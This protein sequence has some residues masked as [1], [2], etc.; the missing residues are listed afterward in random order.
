MQITVNANDINHGMSLVTRALSARPTRNVYE[1]VFAQTVE[2][3]VQLTCTDGIM[4]IRTIV[5]AVVAREGSALLPAKLLSELLRKLE[6]DIVIR[7]EES[8]AT[9]SAQGSRTN[10]LC[11]DMSEFPDIQDVAGDNVTTLPQNKLRDAVNRIIFAASSDEN[12]RIL[13][14]CLMETYPEEVRFVCLDGFRLA[15][16]RVYVTH[17]LPK[18]KDSMTSVIPSTVFGEIARMMPDSDNPATIVCSGTHMMTVFDQTRVYTPLIAGEYINYHQIVPTTWTTEVRVERNAL[19]GAIERAALMAREGKNNLLRLR[20]EKDQLTISANAERGAATEQLSIDFAGSNLDISFN[21]RYLLDVMRN[22]ET[23]DMSM[24]FN[25]NVS[26]CVICP[27][28]GN[29]Y[30]YLVLPVR[31]VD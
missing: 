2:G 22:I 23:Q 11:M 15:M 31:T 9:V 18:G 12:R 10:M 27:V 17:E 19:I 4:T 6:G 1:G 16:Q 8:R 25:T 14:G 21:A 5:N 20:L 3:G 30:T 26:P 29:Q 28:T 13:T 7:V 24:R